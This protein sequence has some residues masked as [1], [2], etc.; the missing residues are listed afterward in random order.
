MTT[1]AGRLFVV[2]PWG[3]AELLL[4]RADEVADKFRTGWGT[5]YTE[6][7]VESCFVAVIDLATLH[8]GRKGW[9]TRQKVPWDGQR[10]YAARRET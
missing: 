6:L 4:P 3:H 2:Q 10:N 1:V 7:D 9:T 8:R 5:K